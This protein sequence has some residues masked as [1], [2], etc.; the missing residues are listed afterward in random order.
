MSTGCA[1]NYQDVAGSTIIGATVSS[2]IVNGTPVAV[3]GDLVNGHGLPPHASPVMATGSSTVFAGGIGVCRVPDVAT[4]GHP[5]SG[6]SN[7]LIG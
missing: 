3:I 4:C 1:R 2:V 7:V 5:T 6:S